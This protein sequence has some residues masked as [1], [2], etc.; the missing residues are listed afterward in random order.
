VTN[1]YIVDCINAGS[2]LPLRRLYYLGMS[3]QTK[4]KFRQETDLFGDRYNE[5][6]CFKASTCSVLLHSIYANLTNK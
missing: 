1:S 4:E 6:W 3:P 5:I 2:L